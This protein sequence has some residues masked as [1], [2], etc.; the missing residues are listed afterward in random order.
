MTQEEFRVAAMR[1][2]FGGVLKTAEWRNSKDSYVPENSPYTVLV[3]AQF[4]KQQR[5]QASRDRGI[6]VEEG[7]GVAGAEERAKTFQAGAESDEKSALMKEIDRRYFEA[8][9]DKT[10]TKIGAGE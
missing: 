5:G 2:I 10:E 3:D 6:S 8:G 1:Q 7:G 9:G 4:L